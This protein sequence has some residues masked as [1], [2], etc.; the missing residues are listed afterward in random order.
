MTEPQTITRR[1][2]MQIVAAAGA[3]CLLPGASSAR[4]TSQTWRGTALGG[5][6]SIQIHVA[7][8]RYGEELLGQCV[9]EIRRLEQVFSLYRSSSALSQLNRHGGLDAPPADLVSLLEKA[10]CFSD[11]TE[12]AFDVTAQ[13]LW[14][15]YAEHFQDPAADPD[16]PN[17]ND[18][19]RI[20]ELVNYRAVNVSTHR[21]ALGRPGMGITLNGIAQGY[22]TDRVSDLL[23]SAGL[24][25][26]LVD[27]GELRALGRH[28]E[29]RSWLVGIRSPVDVDQMTGSIPLE[30]AALATSGG[31]G[32]RFDATGTYHHLFD[33]RT[34]FCTNRYLDMTVIAPN[35][36]MADA[37]STGFSSMEPVQIAYAT[38]M[39]S[40]VTVRATLPDGQLQTWPGS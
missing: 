26:V 8:R 23:R 33:P 34:G 10:R 39:L 25:H 28:P 35:A 3:S 6:A 2:A 21:I 12:G 32:T 22:I 30:S 24:T 37:L 13:P 36:T 18:I 1:R 9:A 31:Y 5:E 19:L 29:G 4:V 14:D 40:S 20:L 7:D 38:G 27:L 16:G 17:R 15:L 11:M